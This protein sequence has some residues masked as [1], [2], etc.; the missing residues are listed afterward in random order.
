MSM[1]FLGIYPG[2]PVRAFPDKFFY[3]L[4]HTINN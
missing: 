2:L 4:L 1:F 3:I